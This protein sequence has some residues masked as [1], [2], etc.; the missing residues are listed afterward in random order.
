MCCVCRDGEGKREDLRDSE[1]GG[2]VLERERERERGGAVLERQ[3][4]R[5]AGQC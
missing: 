5:E 4:E 3:K 2:S 1:R